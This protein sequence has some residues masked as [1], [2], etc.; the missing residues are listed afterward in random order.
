MFDHTTEVRQLGRSQ[1]AQAASTLAGAFIDDPL[2][3]YFFQ[4]EVRRSL[5]LPV[6][7]RALIE[8]LTPDGHTY[9]ISEP[10]HAVALLQPPKRP[11]VPRSRLAAAIVK[12]GM[13]FRPTSIQQ[14]LR[15][16]LSWSNIGRNTTTSTS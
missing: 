11:A 13:S 16:C 1:T 9:Y 12:Y 5:V 14:M 3:T 10:S 15:C 2:Y 8:M 6:L 7:M 4:D